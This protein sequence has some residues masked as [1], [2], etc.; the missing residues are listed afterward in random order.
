[1]DLRRAEGQGR[2][3][4]LTTQ[5]SYFSI[6]PFSIVSFSL[7]SASLVKTKHIIVSNRNLADFV[8]KE[9]P[10]RL[11][12]ATDK[13]STTKNSY[14]QVTRKRQH[15]FDLPNRGI[16]AV[17]CW[18][19]RRHPS[20]PPQM[21]LRCSGL[22]NKSKRRFFTT[23]TC[24]RTFLRAVRRRVVISGGGRELAEAMEADA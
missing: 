1:M 7:S 18:S 2:Y 15:S 19:R 20:L 16:P 13:I 24:I 3:L 23:Q 5:S 22:T 8:F 6:R 4:S 9:L 17:P 14:Y 21:C 12:N 10:F 11:L